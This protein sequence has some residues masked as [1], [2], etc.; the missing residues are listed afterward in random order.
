[1]GLMQSLGFPGQAT[2]RRERVHAT[3]S[4]SHRARLGALTASA[5]LYVDF[6]EYSGHVMAKYAPLDDL[7]VKNNSDEQLTIEIDTDPDRAFTIL[8]RETW[9][10]EGEA[11]RSFKVT[12]EKGQL[13][14]LKNWQASQG[15]ACRS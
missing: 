5:V 11:F 10:M 9:R 3:G 8:P 6:G 7:F 1:M 12:N 13:R 15:L 2:T 14:R 4:K